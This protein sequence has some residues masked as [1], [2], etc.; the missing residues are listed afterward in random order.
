ME[1]ESCK[2]FPLGI[3]ALTVEFG[4]R[5]TTEL[6]DRVLNLA[7]YLTKNPFAGLHEIVPAYSSLTIFYDVLKIRNTFPDFSNAFEAVKS[8]AENGIRNAGAVRTSDPRLIEIPVDFGEDFAPDLEFVAS[9][10]NLSKIEVIEIFTARTYRVFMLGFMPAFP[11]MG[12]VDPR[13]AAP[14]KQTPRLNVPKGSVGIAGTQTGIYPFDSPG[15]WQIIGKTDF[16]LFA[17]EK[18]NPCALNAGDLVKFNASNR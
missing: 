5:I 13:I 10:E 15:G 17:P 3:D 14:R 4:N 16:R 11:Y 2:I 9:I 18:E 8:I 6:N 1:T 12:E 7:D